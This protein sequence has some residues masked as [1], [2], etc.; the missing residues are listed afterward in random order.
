MAATLYT[1]LTGLQVPI[2]RAAIMFGLASLGKLFG[3][4]L[5]GAWV[6]I[7]TAGV[8]LL[9]NPSW[10]TSVSFQLSF[11]ATF[12]VIVV[13]PIILER[14]KLLPQFI[15]VDL[16]VTLAA[17]IMVMPVI[18]A[19]FHQIS[20]VGLI[21]NLL[22]L[23]TIPFIMITGALML[24]VPFIDF[25]ANALLTY[26]IYIIKFFSSLPFAWEYIGEM[27]II[28]WIGYYLVLAATVLSLKY[29]QTNNSG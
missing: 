10:L 12:G 5:D 19:N 17:Q 23:W 22:V 29:V 4:D 14:L 16:A 3:R 28:F 7:L 18:A 15:S 6:L 13:A 9:V 27:S 20:L 8:M 24:V 11:L 2:I 25:A 21:A 1:L 26:F